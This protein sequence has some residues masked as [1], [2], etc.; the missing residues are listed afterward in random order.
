MSLSVSLL[1]FLGLFESASVVQV[2]DSGVQP[3]TA[4]A[5]VILEVYSEEFVASLS[6]DM[7]K[8]AFEMIHNQFALVVGS[9][10]DVAL[11]V[12]SYKHGVFKESGGEARQRRTG[13]MTVYMVH[14]ADRFK[15]MNHQEAEAALATTRLVTA[16]GGLTG[17]QLAR[18]L[19]RFDYAGV[20]GAKLRSV[21]GIAVTTTHTTATSATTTTENTTVLSINKRVELPAAEKDAVMSAGLTAG[22][23]LLAILLVLTMVGSLV[24]YRHRQDAQDRQVQKLLNATAGLSPSVDEEVVFSFSGGEVDPMTGGQFFM[25]GATNNSQTWDRPAAALDNLDPIGATADEL[26]SDFGNPLFAEDGNNGYLA[27]EDLGL[28]LSNGYLA[29][30]DLTLSNGAAD[31]LVNNMYITSENVQGQDQPTSA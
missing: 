11:H 7:D 12:A 25:D 17:E 24:A 30:E 29:G 20:F 27:G 13:L 8:A 14:L 26:N 3:H 31:L 16:Y 28:N 6:M 1:C 5:S 18:L 15:G 2:S 9:A 22:L 21:G 19:A 23:T 4:N 10:L